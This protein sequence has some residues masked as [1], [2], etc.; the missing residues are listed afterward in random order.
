M[1]DEAKGSIDGETDVQPATFLVAAN[2][3]HHV[4]RSL[5]RAAGRT[6]P[7]SEGWV[8]TTGINKSIFRTTRATNLDGRIVT[9]KNELGTPF[10]LVHDGINVRQ[11]LRLA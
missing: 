5:S 1:L 10:F 3:P 2:A 9:V 8:A 6:P 11:T 7:L 4:R